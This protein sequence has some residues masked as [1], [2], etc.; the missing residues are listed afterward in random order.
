MN[1]SSRNIVD[2]STKYYYLDPFLNIFSGLTL[3]QIAGEHFQTVPVVLDVALKKI[4]EHAQIL[5][6][7]KTLTKFL[8][9][10]C[11]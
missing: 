9:K 6:S 7:N 2:L 11:I 5:K 1:L 10:R 8:L 4:L 3:R